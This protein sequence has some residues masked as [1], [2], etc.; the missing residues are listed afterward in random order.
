VNS[1]DAGHISGVEALK[2]IR[3]GTQ[4][5]CPVCTAI[6]E[7]VPREW[8]LG[9]PLHGIQ[10]PNSQSHFMIHCDEESAMKEMRRRMAARSRLG[11]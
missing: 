11:K 3:D 9:M 6:L 8:K 5:T 10:C 2:L 1:I 4:L 7:T